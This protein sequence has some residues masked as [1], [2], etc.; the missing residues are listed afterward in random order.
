MQKVKVLSLAALMALWLVP[1]LAQGQPSISGDLSGTLGP[2]DYIV[3]GDCQVPSGQTLDILPGTT[4]MFSGHYFFKVYGQLN[5]EG[6]AEDQIYFVRQIPNESC[7]HGGIRFQSGSSPNSTLSYCVI[8]Y[9]KN[10]T[11]PD[12][13]GGGIYCSNVGVTISNCEISNCYASTGGGLYATNSSVEITDC[14]F[15]GNSAG[16][17]GGVYL[18]NSNGASVNNSVFYKNA[19]TST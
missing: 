8:D 17:G 14:V 3:V 6:T 5:A 19:S 12:Y 15:R 11:Y 10:Y 4:L 18:N 13:Y 1:L 2:G 9:A 7:K 16:N